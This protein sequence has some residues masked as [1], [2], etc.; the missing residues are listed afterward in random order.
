MSPTWVIILWLLYSFKVPGSAGTAG[1]RA[2]PSTLDICPGQ[3]SSGCSMCH[4]WFR[5]TSRSRWDIPCLHIPSSLMQAMCRLSQP[6]GSLTAL[7]WPAFLKKRA[8][9]HGM[10]CADP[11]SGC[12]GRGGTVCPPSPSNARVCSTRGQRRKVEM[13][14]SVPQEVLPPFFNMGLLGSSCPQF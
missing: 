6:S 5:R 11:L 14:I 3:G 10:V 7:F 8:P 12:F 2:A 9:W 13:G 4:S 1:C